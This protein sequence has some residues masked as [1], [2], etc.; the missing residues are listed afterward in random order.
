[1]ENKRIYKYNPIEDCYAT[2]KKIHIFRDEIEK[3]SSK[4]KYLSILDFGCGNG[5]LANAFAPKVKKVIEF[6]YTTL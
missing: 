6:F 5:V 4:K 3:R 1:M 2:K